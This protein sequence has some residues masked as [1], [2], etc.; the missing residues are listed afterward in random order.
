MVD[1]KKNQVILIIDYETLDTEIYNGEGKSLH[2]EGEIDHAKDGG[3][4]ILINMRIDL[5]E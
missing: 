3:K 2:I 5:E 4:S 1:P